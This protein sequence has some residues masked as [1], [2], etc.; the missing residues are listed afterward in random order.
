METQE[1][2]KTRHTGVETEPRPRHEKQ[3][4]DKTRVL[5]LHQCALVP[6]I[7]MSFVIAEA[8]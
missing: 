8:S 4:R 7:I 5:R 1:R 2:A 6:E 3:S